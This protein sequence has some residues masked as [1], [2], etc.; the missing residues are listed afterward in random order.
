MRQLRA[1]ETSHCRAANSTEIYGSLASHITYGSRF[2]GRSASMVTAR[3]NSP[4]LATG[5]V[6]SA[7]DPGLPGMKTTA[8]AA[9]RGPATSGGELI[10]STPTDVFFISLQGQNRASGKL[11]LRPVHRVARRAQRAAVDRPTRALAARPARGIG[12]DRSG[13]RQRY[14]DV[15]MLQRL[16][17]RPRSSAV[18]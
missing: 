3:A 2:S 15:S 17:P 8:S 10:A 11:P 18:R 7:I 12:P 13:A 5:C 9:S 14:G 4:T 6:K 1:G 16:S